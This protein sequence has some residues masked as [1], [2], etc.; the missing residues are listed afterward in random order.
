L[1]N[2]K[3][4]AFQ[5]LISKAI[6]AYLRH[7]PLQHGKWRLLESSTGFL[8]VELEPGVLVR[9]SSME[10]S[11]VAKGWKEVEEA[12][13]LIS[14]LKPGM[15]FFDV[16]ANIGLYS[17]LAAK[18]VGPR[19]VVHSFEP[20]PATAVR[21]EAN[22]G[23]NNFSNIKVNQVALSD[24]RGT[25]KFY[26]HQADDRNS[27]SAISSNSIVIPTITLDEYIA[28]NLISAVDLMKMDVEGAELLVLQG[29]SKLISGRNAPT[30]MLEIN[31]PALEGMGTS[32]GDLTAL[33]NECGYELRTLAQHSGYRNVLATKHPSA[34]H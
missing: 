20:T 29:A 14:L 34:R 13:H 26:L 8:T 6:V 10:D 30:I 18:R 31:G 25:A 1:P 27:L 19:G 12:K 23:L 17:I 15:T 4:T 16:G 21:L 32:E 33:L 24:K 2:K 7:I 22:V 28:E 9:V 3:P 5:Q 11:Y